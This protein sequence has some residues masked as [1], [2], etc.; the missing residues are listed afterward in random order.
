VVVQSDTSYIDEQGTAHITRVVPVPTTVSPEAQRVLARRIPDVAVKETMEQHRASTDV[1]QSST[2]DQ[3]RMGY[4]LKSIESQTIAGVPVR[5]L[6]PLTIPAGKTDRVLIN[7]HGGGFNSDAGSL[8]ESIPI[9]NL[10]QTCVIAVLYRLAPEHPYPAALEDAIEVYKEVLMTHKPQNV[11][12]YG[13][14]A[15]AV[16]TAEVAAKLK[17]LG[18]PQ[19]GALGIFSGSG[20]FSRQGDSRALFTLAGLSGHM[21]PPSQ[22]DG[23]PNAYL[24]G[25]SATDPVISPLFSDLHGLPP[26]LFVTSERDLLLSGT[27]ILHRAYLKAGVDAQMVV[28]EGLGHAFWNDPQLPESAE[29]NGIMAAFFDKHLGR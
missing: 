23:M 25:Q 16:L 26:T 7:L 28:F 14:S 5:V 24:A 3:A 11:A 27:A 10:S 12:I 6:T 13:T 21:D 17:Q 20:D 22:T 4:P 19:P 18:L 1:W 29:A 9:A 8:T 2:A 15:G